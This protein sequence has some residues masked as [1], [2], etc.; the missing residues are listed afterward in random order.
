MGGVDKAICVAPFFKRTGRTR[1]QL[2]IDKL[3]STSTFSGAL[4]ISN[5]EPA[6]NVDYSRTA[7]EVALGFKWSPSLFEQTANGS[8]AVTLSIR[9]I[10][11]ERSAADW[12]DALEVASN[13]S[14]S[15]GEVNA[16]LTFGNVSW[17]VPEDSVS[18]SFVAFRI[19]VT[20]P[21]TID[22]LPIVYVFKTGKVLMK[23][24]I[25]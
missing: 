11:F 12:K 1:V 22:E 24:H 6:L 2:T 25:T 8:N 18:K 4:T 7:N 15:D 9:M 3:S 23:S 16:T 10:V 13:V 14:N 20:D 21:E 17:L 5:E 19:D